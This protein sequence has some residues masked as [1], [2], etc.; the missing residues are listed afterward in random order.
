MICEVMCIE[1]LIFSC[2]GIVAV[3]SAIRIDDYFI[4]TASAV[5]LGISK[6]VFCDKCEC[7]KVQAVTW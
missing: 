3:V 7:V 2:K 6:L 1:N 5:Y 4:S